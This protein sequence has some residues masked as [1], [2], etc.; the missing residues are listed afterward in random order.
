MWSET[1]TSNPPPNGSAEWA[2]R[3]TIGHTERMQ[4]KMYEVKQKT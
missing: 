1:A 4:G 3:R 2:E